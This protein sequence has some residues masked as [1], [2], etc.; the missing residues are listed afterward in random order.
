MQ[1]NSLV[2]ST[3]RISFFHV[4]MNFTINS[5][6]LTVKISGYIVPILDVWCS[7]VTHWYHS[8]ALFQTLVPAIYNI[9]TSLYLHHILELVL[10]LQ[11]WPSARQGIKP[12]NV[13]RCHPSRC[14]QKDGWHALIP[15]QQCPFLVL[16]IEYCF[17]LMSSS[18]PNDASDRISF[19]LPATT[20]N[21]NLRNNS[22]DTCIMEFVLRSVNTIQSVS[23]INVH[24]G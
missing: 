2:K 24:E 7:C 16:H 6:F 15:W 19:G 13:P 10:V 14:L 1:I 22:L 4:W 9:Y 18:S 8:R 20:H 3:V 21:T 23:G 11:C 12:L 17:P 5:A